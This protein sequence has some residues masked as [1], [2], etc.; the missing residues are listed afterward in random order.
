MQSWRKRCNLRKFLLF[1]FQIITKNY[2]YGISLD[3]RF[4]IAL[5]GPGIKFLLILLIILAAPL[6]LNKLRI[7]HLLGLIIAGAIIGP[8]GFNLVL[9]G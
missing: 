7:P 2:A 4:H 5:S 6:L 3:N 9:R 1:L 8:H